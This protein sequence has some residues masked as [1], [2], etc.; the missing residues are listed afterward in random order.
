MDRMLVLAAPVAAGVGGQA[1]TADANGRDAAAGSIP[2]E[3]GL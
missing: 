1:A 3:P 2:R